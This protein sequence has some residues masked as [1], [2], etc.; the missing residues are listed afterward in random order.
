M[1]MMAP[2]ALEHRHILKGYVQTLDLYMGSNQKVFLPL[3]HEDHPKLDDSPLCGPDDT[4]KFQSLI[5]ACQ[6][7]ISLSCIDLAHAVMSL[8]QFHH[9]PCIGHVDKLKHICGYVWKFPQATL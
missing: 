7:M 5:G 4:A 1:M 9:C 2:F 6:W 3:D 8:S